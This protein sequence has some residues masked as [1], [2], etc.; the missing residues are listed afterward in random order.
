MRGNTDTRTAGR[1]RG[2]SNYR[3]G[4]S[5][6]S[7]RFNGHRSRSGRAADLLAGFT[8]IAEQALDGDILALLCDDLEQHAVVL[9]RD[10]VGEFICRDL[11]DSLASLDSIPLMLEP[12]GYCA[13]FHRQSQLGHKNFVSHAIPSLTD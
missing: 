1:Y 2:G 11:K 6:G 12:A 7:H 9:A 8:D 10:L 5:S 4:G 13:F 3:R